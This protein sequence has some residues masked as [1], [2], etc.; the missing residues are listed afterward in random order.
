MFKNEEYLDSFITE[1]C[2]RIRDRYAKWK[3]L[4]STKKEITN[5]F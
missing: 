5:S 2:N 4:C 3:R 1:F